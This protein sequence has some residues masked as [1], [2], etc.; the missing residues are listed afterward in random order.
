LSGNPSHAG[1]VLHGNKA[2]GKPAIK[3]DVV[4]KIVRDIEV[5][6]SFF[7]GLGIGHVQVDVSYDTIA[8][9]GVMQ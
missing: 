4:K 3:E 8:L 2:A 5:A 6:V 1:A 9:K 7:V